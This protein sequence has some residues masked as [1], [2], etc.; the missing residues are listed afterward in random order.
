MDIF[1]RIDAQSTDSDQTVSEDVATDRIIEKN[2]TYG[3]LFVLDASKQDPLYKYSPIT[4][5]NIKTGFFAEKRAERFYNFLLKPLKRCDSNEK[6]QRQKQKRLKKIE[7]YLKKGI[8]FDEYFSSG[9]RRAVLEELPGEEIRLLH[10]HGYNIEATIGS[11]YKYDNVFSKSIYYGISDLD[12]YILRHIPT[13]MLEQLI[14]TRQQLNISKQTIESFVGNFYFS[15]ASRSIKNIQLLI[16]TGQIYLTPKQILTFCDFAEKEG[17]KL[18]PEVVA[19][20]QLAEQKRPDKPE[21]KYTTQRRLV[22]RV[23]QQ[24]KAEQKKKSE[25]QEAIDKL[26]EDAQKATE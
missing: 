1:S 12:S 22:R 5:C 20:K 3:Y 8:N 6:Y 4:N 18:I 11:I 24:K 17:F 2:G 21:E 13:H 23:D 7:K 10:S 14:H 19:L 9:M 15:T 16:K 26:F 25:A